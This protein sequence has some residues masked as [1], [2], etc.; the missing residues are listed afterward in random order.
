MLNILV[1]SLPLKAVNT[2]IAR[3]IKS[4]YSTKAMNEAASVSYIDINGLVEHYHDLIEFKSNITRILRLP[5]FL[6]YPSRVIHWGAYEHRLNKVLKRRQF[7]VLHESFF[8]PSK[9]RTD[10]YQVFTLHDLSLLIYPEHHTQDRVDFFNTYFEKRIN[11]A[12][13]FI[14]PTRYIKNQFCSQCDIQPQMVSVVNEAVTS[15]FHPA[16]PDD[17]SAVIKKYSLPDDYFLFVGTMDPRKNLAIV[18]EAM[19][20][21]NNKPNLVIAGWEG[22]GSRH[23]LERLKSLSLENSVYFTG[24]VE[25]HDLISLYSGAKAFLYPSLYEGF[26]LPLLEAMACGCPVIASNA[27]CL[28]EVGGNACLYADPTSKYEWGEALERLLE[29]HSSSE[30]LRHEGFIRA[31]E[32]SW[33]TAARQT[34]QVFA[35]YAETGP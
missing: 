28:P 34:L 15:N 10:I 29:D 14:V 2:G 31:R 20:L 27:A 21:M 1:N 16:S 30:S 7:D 6:L 12:D 26:G 25:D 33:E 4:L 13:H 35:K 23:F 9:P 8:T 11:E 24:Y 3:Y 5:S 32:F 19:A 18:L 17:I 22:W